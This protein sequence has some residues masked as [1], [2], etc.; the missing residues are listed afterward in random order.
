MTIFMIV[1]AVA[2]LASFTVAL[3]QHE[4][5]HQRIEKQL[6]EAQ[7]RYTNSKG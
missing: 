4:K 7:D 6:Q 2:C 1:T 3:V 5:R